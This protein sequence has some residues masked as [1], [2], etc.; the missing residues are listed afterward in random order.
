M[1]T[2]FV[3][4]LTIGSIGGPS[5]REFADVAGLLGFSNQIRIFS[6]GGQRIRRS[7][8]TLRFLLRYYT[9]KRGKVVTDKILRSLSEDR[10][11]EL[12]IPMLFSEGMNFKAFACLHKDQS[13]GLKRFAITLKF[14]ELT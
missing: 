9:V 11:N 2:S 12:R 8:V 6:R 3:K 10:P 7:A 5:S 13:R 4:V 14:E 1:H